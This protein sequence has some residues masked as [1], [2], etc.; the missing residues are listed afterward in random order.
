MTQQKKENAQTFSLSSF[1]EEVCLLCVREERSDISTW[2]K[3]FSF[4]Y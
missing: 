4:L 3:T 1:K 2:L